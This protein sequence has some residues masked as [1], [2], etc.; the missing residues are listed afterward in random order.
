M[1]FRDNCSDLYYKKRKCSLYNRNK[2]A[3]KREVR[4]IFMSTVFRQL[5]IVAKGN[6]VKCKKVPTFCEKL[7]HLLVFFYTYKGLQN[8][9][10]I[11]RKPTPIQRKRG[12]KLTPKRSSGT[13]TELSEPQSF[14]IRILLIPLNTQSNLTGINKIRLR[15]NYLCD[16]CDL[17]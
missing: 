9:R 12:L 2:Y 17:Y 16:P 7:F 3:E 14:L 4:N 11:L 1:N 6:S 13:L 5:G 10:L 8:E 15:N